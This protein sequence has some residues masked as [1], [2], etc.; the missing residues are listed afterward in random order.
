VTTRTGGS[1]T[2]KQRR[3]INYHNEITMWSNYHRQT[4]LS[5]SNHKIDKRKKA[6]RA[7]QA[8]IDMNKFWQ[9]EYHP[10][11]PCRNKRKKKDRT[12]TSNQSWWF[13]YIVRQRNAARV[14]SLLSALKSVDRKWKKLIKLPFLYY[15]SCWRCHRGDRKRWVFD[16]SSAANENCALKKSCACLNSRHHNE[17]P[18]RAGMR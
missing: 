12:R 3:P 6:E 11:T 15:S 18:E 13:P 16:S 10:V 8:V 5:R 2:G 17:R 14:S 7:T 9:L 1:K 4:F